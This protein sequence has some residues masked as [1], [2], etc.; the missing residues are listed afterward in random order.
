MRP[1]RAPGSPV[2]PGAAGCERQAA[3]GILRGT[4]ADAPTVSTLDRV[5]QLGRLGS[6]AIWFYQGLVPKLLGPHPEELAMAG[7]FGLAPGFQR[8]AS[9]TAAV[10][11]IVLAACIVAARRQVWPHALSVF[12]CIALLA[13]VVIFAPSH[14]VAPF[15]PVA[16]NVALG[17]LSL[18]TLLC[19][20]GLGSSAR[21]HALPRQH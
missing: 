18:I 7:A 8:A 10:L 17:V 1:H 12:A 4:L 9:Y 2:R 15:N 11:E 20:R 6:G 5:A 3:H 21:P 19:I 13:F 16:L 14:L